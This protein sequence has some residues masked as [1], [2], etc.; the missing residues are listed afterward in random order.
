LRSWKFLAARFK[1]KPEK[2]VGQVVD[3]LVELGM[4]RTEDHADGTIYIMLNDRAPESIPADS[5]KE[6]SR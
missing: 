5:P 3:A 6:L 4:I 1:R 2:S